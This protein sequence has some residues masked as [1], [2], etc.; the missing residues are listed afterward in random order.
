VKGTQPPLQQK[1][2]IHCRQAD[3]PEAQAQ[4]NMR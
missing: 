3:R 1:D 4:A 2:V